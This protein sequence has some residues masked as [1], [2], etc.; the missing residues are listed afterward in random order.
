MSIVSSKYFWQTIANDILNNYISRTIGVVGIL[1]NFSFVVLLR[2]QSLQHKVYDFMWTKTMCNLVACLMAAGYL[3][4][5]FDCTFEYEWMAYY[6]W[7]NR[8]AARASSLSVF[9]SEI[10][11]IY[12][13]YSEIKKKKFFWIKFSKE[14]N[15][16]ICILVGFLIM[17]PI[18]LGKDI[19]ESPKING[20]FTTKFNK[21]GSSIYFTVYVYAVFFFES[22]VPV[23]VMVYLNVVTVYNFKKIMKKHGH[24]TKNKSAAKQAEASFTKMVIFLSTFISITRFIDLITITLKRLTVINQKLFEPETIELITFLKNLSDFFLTTCFALYSLVLL[25]MDKNLF[26]LILKIT[27]IW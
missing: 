23:S 9:I 15:F 19:I 10:F 12:N 17:L 7:Y 11:L 1:L 26:K 25:R 6:S 16:L 27:G 24:L 20:T 4:I 2:H 18:A 8:V 14:L 21:I 3:D 22:V 5:C 13:R